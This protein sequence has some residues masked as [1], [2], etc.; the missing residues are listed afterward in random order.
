MET[1]HKISQLNVQCIFFFNVE[2][3]IFMYK[4]KYNK[5]IKPWQEIKNEQVNTLGN[6]LKKNNNMNRFKIVHIHVWNNKYIYLD[7]SKKYY[8]F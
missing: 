8:N 6:I 5:M 4:K 7:I 2:Q 3:I 1:G